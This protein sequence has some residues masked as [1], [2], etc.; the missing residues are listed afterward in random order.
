MDTSS[1]CACSRAP[2]CLLY[3]H[4]CQKALVESTAGN[5]VELL[6]DFAGFG[7]PLNVWGLGAAAA[8]IQTFS[9]IW[10]C[11]ERWQ[12]LSSPGSFFRA[13][14]SL[15]AALRPL[16][17]FCADHQLCVC[18]LGLNASITETI[19]G[20]ALEIKWFLRIKDEEKA[21]GRCVCQSTAIDSFM[22]EPKT[23]RLSENV[24]L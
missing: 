5:S 14:F 17:H 11:Q 24:K 10:D 2:G 4:K 13:A 16:I 22:K 21:N 19:E 6:P 1:L 12:V 15:A 20:N 18:L 3:L 9:S 23:S 7:S 8:F